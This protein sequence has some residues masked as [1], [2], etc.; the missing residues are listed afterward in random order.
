MHAQSCLTLFNPVDCRPPGSSAHGISQAGILEWVAIS[1]SRESSRP[2]DS[3]CVS[4][5]GR[6]ILYYWATREAPGFHQVGKLNSLMAGTLTSINLSGSSL[7]QWPHFL[8]TELSPTPP[9]RVL[10]FLIQLSLHQGDT[11]SE[12]STTSFLLTGS[13]TSLSFL[14]SSHVGHRKTP[15]ETLGK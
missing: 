13:P 11:C 5:M 2:R 9:K 4:C 3:S 14:H 1:S 12:S 15:E 7:T 8:I 10:P 6:W